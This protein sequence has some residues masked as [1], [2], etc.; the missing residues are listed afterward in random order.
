MSIT[1]GGGSLPPPVAVPPPL[2]DPQGGFHAIVRTYTAVS[3]KQRG[4]NQ[5]RGAGRLF[6]SGGAAL[7]LYVY[8]L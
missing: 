5:G 3:Q 7:R 2:W 4:T 8:L 1:L 6:L